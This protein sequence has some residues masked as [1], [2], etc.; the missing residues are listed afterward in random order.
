MGWAHVWM[1]IETATLA[2]FMHCELPF[3]VPMMKISS[4]LLV[5]V[6]AAVNEVRAR[7]LIAAARTIPIWLYTKVNNKCVNIGPTL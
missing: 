2:I 7:A 3:R 4:L 6:P 5:L 1:C